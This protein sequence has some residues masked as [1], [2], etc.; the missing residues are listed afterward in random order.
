MYRLMLLLD[1]YKPIVF[2][3]KIA[4]IDA[5][6]LGVERFTRTSSSPCLDGAIIA[7]R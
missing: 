3:N 4:V 7:G 1:R 2:T 6:G 5:S